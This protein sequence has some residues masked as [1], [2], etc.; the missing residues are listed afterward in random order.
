MYGMIASWRLE[1]QKQTGMNPAWTLL[2]LLV[3]IIQ[4]DDHETSK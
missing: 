4:C 2:D 1:Q 3:H